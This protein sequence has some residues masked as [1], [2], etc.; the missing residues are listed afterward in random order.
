MFLLYYSAI[1][2]ASEVNKLIITVP[3]FSDVDK[4]FVIT[5]YSEVN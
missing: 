3:A 4:Y 2:P 1:L 5:K